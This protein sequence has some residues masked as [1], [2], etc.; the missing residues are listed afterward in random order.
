VMKLAVRV[1][2]SIDQVPGQCTNLLRADQFSNF[3]CSAGD[4]AHT[5]QRGDGVGK[6]VALVMRS[7]IAR[8]R[9]GDSMGPDGL[10]A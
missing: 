4:C 3:E 2:L 8:L 6:A 9:R 10:A 7:A 5:E 1:Y